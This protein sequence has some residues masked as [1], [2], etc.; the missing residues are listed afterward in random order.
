VSAPQDTQA[1]KDYFAREA[2]RFDAIYDNAN[3]SP[4][5]K[6]VDVA[7]RTRML[8]KRNEVIA[9]LVDEGANCFE[10]GTGSGRTAVALA[11]MRGARVHGIDIAAPMIELAERRASEAGVSELCRFEVADFDSFTPT[12]RYDTFV[13]VG[14]LDYFADPLPMLRRAAK[15]FVRPGGSIVISWPVKGQLLNAAR[16]TWLKTKGVPVTFYDEREVAGLAGAVG[17]KNVHTITTGVA[18]ILRDGV[19]RIALSS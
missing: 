18:P 16:R 8:N 5:Q 4:L 7:F 15:E 9:S 13:A 12:E 19:A 2:E 3:K 6:F 17:G 11:S 1:V 14:V 10:I